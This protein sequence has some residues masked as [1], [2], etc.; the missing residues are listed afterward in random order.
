MLPALRDAAG[1]FLAGEFA[2]T[3]AV[4]AAAFVL[5]TAIGF[6]RQWRQRSA[7]LRTT[8]L[9]AVGAAAFSELGMRLL[10]RMGRRGSSPMSC[11]A[12]ASWVRG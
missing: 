6:E 11:P 1:R 7:G 5:G 8:V 2:Q 3:L 12:S 4:L 9:V 10:A